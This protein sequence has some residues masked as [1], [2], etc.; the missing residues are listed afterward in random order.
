MIFFFVQITMDGQREQENNDVRTELGLAIASPG[1][2]NLM[3]QD[4][5][6]VLDGHLGLGAN[7]NTGNTGDASATATEQDS[8]ETRGHERAAAR[9]STN[10]HNREQITKLEA[11]VCN[12]FLH[13]NRSIFI[14]FY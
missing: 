4:H 1:D 9:R 8:G 7:T 5:G 12:I 6:G 11:Y 13:E 14:Y 2:D 10:R 3:S